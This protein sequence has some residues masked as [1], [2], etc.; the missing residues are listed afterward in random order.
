MAEKT[1][2]D[3]KKL[4]IK[5]VE[6]Y[7]A[8]KQASPEMGA[9]LKGHCPEEILDCCD[10]A[11]DHAVMVVAHLSCCCCHDDGDDHHATPPPKAP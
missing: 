2:E 10:A 3:A 6:D 5:K 8:Q 7:F 11:L 1:F 4:A 9:A